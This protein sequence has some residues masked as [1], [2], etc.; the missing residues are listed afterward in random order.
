MHP[1][2]LVLGATLE[3]FDLPNDLMA[4][5][6]GKSQLGRKGLIVATA[7]QV[8]PGFHGVVVLELVNAGMVPLKIRPGMEISQLV[9]QTLTEPVPNEFLYRGSSYC[10]IKP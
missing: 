9:F 7:A 10:Q 6:E 3:F 1:G 5:V 2:D 4:Y 8:A